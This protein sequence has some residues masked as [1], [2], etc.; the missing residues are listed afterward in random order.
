MQNFIGHRKYIDSLE[1][2][3]TYM[4]LGKK[5]EES[6]ILLQKNALY[7]EAVYMYIQSMEKKIKG[8]ICKKINLSLRYYADKLRDIGH[9]LDKSIDFLIEILAGNDD[10]LRKQLSMQVKNGVFENIEFSKLYNNCRYPYYHL[11]KGNY[12]MLNIDAQD[13]LRIANIN[14]K[15]DN[16]IRDFD[17]L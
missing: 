1:M 14:K 4:S 7:N 12:S 10:T 6:A 2:S 9:S 3:E 13:C 17:R 15:L 5:D 16:F 8:Y 11:Q